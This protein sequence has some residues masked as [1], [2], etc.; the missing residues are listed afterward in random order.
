MADILQNNEIDIT[1]P[2]NSPSFY[3]TFTDSLY[4][5]QIEGGR[6][7]YGGLLR[8]KEVRKETITIQAGQPN[9]MLPD[10][11]PSIE[12]FTFQ[13]KARGLPFIFTFGNASIAESAIIQEPVVNIK[14]FIV[15]YS[16]WGLFSGDVTIS[17][18]IY[19]LLVKGN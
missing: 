19:E 9:P 14:D 10:Y 18:F 13:H 15:T 6:N 17:F 7:V 3:K 1:D 5:T 4:K 12:S 16:N 8:L 2:N 11:G